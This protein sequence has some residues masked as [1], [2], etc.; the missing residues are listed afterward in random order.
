MGSQ[1]AT[2][3]CRES[4]FS[5]SCQEPSKDKTPEQCSLTNNCQLL[6]MGTV[7]SSRNATAPNSQE[8]IQVNFAL[9]TLL[10]VGPLSIASDA[11][12]CPGCLPTWAK[13]SHCRGLRVS[14]WAAGHCRHCQP[15]SKSDEFSR[16]NLCWACRLRCLWSILRLPSSPRCS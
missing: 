5:E 2:G 7:R 11:S 14:P 10:S 3:S 8:A 1:A 15:G 4:K 12:R 13:A 16:C 6:Q 9:S